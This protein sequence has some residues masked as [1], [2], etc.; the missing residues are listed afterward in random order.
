MNQD[1]PSQ[2]MEISLKKNKYK[3]KKG[4]LFDQNMKKKK[5]P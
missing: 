2:G 5:I 1:I 3:V 4:K